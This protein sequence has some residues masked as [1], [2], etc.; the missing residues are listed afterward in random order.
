[1]KKK[2]WILLLTVAALVILTVLCINLLS[3]CGTVYD[4]IVADGYQGTE[5]QWLASL[6]GEQSAPGT[7]ETAYA[8]ACQNGYTQTFDVWMKTV[9]GATTQ[10]TATPAF[11]VACENGYSG[12]IAQWLESLVA[13]P[14]TL[15]RSEQDEPKTEYELACEFGFQGTFSE[16]L[17]S[18]ANEKIYR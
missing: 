17:V 7:V 6:V 13:A 4:E 15:G 3:D 10:D 12:T 1:M 9:A 11:T 2:T 16:W 8:L 18:L 5:E 14:E